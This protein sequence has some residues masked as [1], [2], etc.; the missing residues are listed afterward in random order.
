MGANSRI[1]QAVMTK[2]GRQGPGYYAMASDFGSSNRE[3][4]S[5]AVTANPVIETEDL[6]LSSFTCLPLGVSVGTPAHHDATLG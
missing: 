2:T 6:V 4:R 1:A 3:G 5:N